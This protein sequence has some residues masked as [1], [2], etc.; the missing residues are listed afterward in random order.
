M[1]T[2]YSKL[3]SLAHHA[4]EVG[5]QYGKKT[6]KLHRKV[7]K[8]NAK[9]QPDTDSLA[10][11]LLHEL[12]HLDVETTDTELKEKAR[13]FDKLYKKGSITKEQWESAKAQLAKIREEKD[14]TK[15]ANKLKEAITLHKQQE[16]GAFRAGGEHQK[17]NP[18]PQPEKTPTPQEKEKYQATLQFKQYYGDLTPT[19]YF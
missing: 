19:A 15:G 8:N 1:N 3:A 6:E 10:E 13:E 7:P 5:K 16:N 11:F 18:K 17:S 12:E 2:L 4:K 9:K 14:L